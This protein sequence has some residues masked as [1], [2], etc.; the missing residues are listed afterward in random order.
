MDQFKEILN[1]ILGIGQEAPQSLTGTPAEVS[2]QLIAA[3][4]SALNQLTLMEEAFLSLVTSP[5]AITFAVG[6]LV[7]CLANL[8]LGWTQAST[9]DQDA[10]QNE[11]S[12]TIQNEESDANQNKEPDANQ[13]EEPEPG[14][15]QCVTTIDQNANHDGTDAIPDLQ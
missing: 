4:T 1:K 5:A 10:K 8:I 3:G 14:T 9:N 11:E 15:I 13:N 6:I 7:G 2:E 12:D